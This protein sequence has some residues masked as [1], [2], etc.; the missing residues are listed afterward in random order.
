MFPILA[1]NLV[2]PCQSLLW[3]KLAFVLRAYSLP[4]EEY[5]HVDVDYLRRTLRD[6]LVLFEDIF[7]PS[8]CTYNIHVVSRKNTCFQHHAF[9]TRVL[10]SCVT[11][12]C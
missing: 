1:D 4:E 2:D 7:S 6:F 11:Y 3:A 12:L 10:Y 9:I 8:N 5:Q